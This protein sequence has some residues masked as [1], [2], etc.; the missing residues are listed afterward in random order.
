MGKNLKWGK[1]GVLCKIEL[2][3]ERM[4]KRGGKQQFMLLNI[5]ALESFFKIIFTFLNIKLLKAFFLIF[6]FSLFFPALKSVRES[7]SKLNPK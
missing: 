1:R 3:A 2:I 4:E 6:K 7:S 5:K